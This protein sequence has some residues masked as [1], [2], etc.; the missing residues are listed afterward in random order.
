MSWEPVF[1][2]GRGPAP[3]AAA[4][5]VTY[6]MIPSPP[7]DKLQGSEFSGFELAQMLIQANVSY[8]WGA[9]AVL[10]AMLQIVRNVFE[11]GCT[12]LAERLW[13]AGPYLALQLLPCHATGDY[14]P[15][16]NAVLV[17]KHTSVSE[18]G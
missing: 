18:L 12:D 16:W 6:N 8:K 15:F 5:D 1:K 13:V 3:A 10:L 2:H 14:G 17:S 7:I 4:E 11:S 9:E